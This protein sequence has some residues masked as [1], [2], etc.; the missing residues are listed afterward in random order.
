VPEALKAGLSRRD[1]DTLLIRNP[2][3]ALTPSR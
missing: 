3:A 2:R 1:V